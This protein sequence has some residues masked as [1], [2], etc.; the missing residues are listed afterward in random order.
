MATYNL[1]AGF[2]DKISLSTSY[3]QE[4]RNRLVEFGDGYIQRTPLGINNLVRRIS[5]SW[6]NLTSSERDTLLNTIEFCQG[7]GDA[8]YIPTSELFQFGG[9]YYVEGIDVQ[10]A[11]NQRV[12]VTASL[13]EV[14]D[15]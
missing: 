5:I 15:L 12:T 13:R 3:T 6:E 4:A 11:D 10:L 8:V 9:Q 1:P 7:T 2:E 14:F